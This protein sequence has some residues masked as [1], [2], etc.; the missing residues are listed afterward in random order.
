MQLGSA[1]DTPQIEY[2]TEVMKKLVLD[3]RIFLC[4]AEPHWLYST[5]YKNDS[6]F[7]NRN[8]GFFEGHVLQNIS[9][10][11]RST[12]FLCAFKLAYKN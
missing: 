2:F 3:D 6:A 10:S 5:L 11:A 7:D 12:K 8:M 1:L 4:N 9:P